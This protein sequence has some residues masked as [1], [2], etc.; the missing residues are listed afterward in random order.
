M[1]LSD[2]VT[3]SAT[4]VIEMPTSST[5]VSMEVKINIDYSMLQIRW[6]PSLTPLPVT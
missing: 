5:T 1:E 4:T 3:N 2:S 6:T